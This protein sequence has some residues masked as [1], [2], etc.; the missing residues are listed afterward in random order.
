MMKISSLSWCSIR[1]TLKEIHWELLKNLSSLTWSLPQRYRPS[2]KG[3]TALT[4]ISQEDCLK[5][6]LAI[7]YASLI[8]TPMQTLNLSTDSTSL[9]TF[10]GYHRMSGC[11]WY[12]LGPLTPESKWEVSSAVF[13]L[14]SQYFTLSPFWTLKLSTSQ[15]SLILQIWKQHSIRFQKD[16]LSIPWRMM[17]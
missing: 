4:M 16:Q 2:S 12:S 7:R 8:S 6:P 10:Q 3:Y 1:I 9:V 15:N 5:C 14:C 17:N 11:S 13:S